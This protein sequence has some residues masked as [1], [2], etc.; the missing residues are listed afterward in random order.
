M[1]RLKFEDTAV[2]K[3]FKECDG[4]IKKFDVYVSE[5]ERSSVSSLMLHE[6]SF[7]ACRVL[8]LL[9]KSKEKNRQQY[10][11]LHGDVTPLP[12]VSSPRSD[13][14]SIEMSKISFTESPNLLST[15]LNGFV[16]EQED[17]LDELMEMKN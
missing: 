14:H 1:E 11:E 6:E 4:E 13:E 16:S 9:Q 12:E 8:K 5:L 17:L 2:V 3:K 15:P 7:I 10:V